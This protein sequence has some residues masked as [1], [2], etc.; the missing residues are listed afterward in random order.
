M[1]KKS[2][3]DHITSLPVLMVI[4]FIAMVSSYF[5]FIKPS[6]SYIMNSDV[7]IKNSF[8]ETTGSKNIKFLL[9]P[10]LFPEIKK[11]SHYQKDITPL[12]LQK[13]ALRM[14]LKLIKGVKDNPKSKQ[15]IFD[16][17]M[18]Y[19]VSSGVKTNLYQLKD[20]RLQRLLAGYYNLTIFNEMVPDYKATKI[21]AIKINQLIIKKINNNPVLYN[22]ISQPLTKNYEITPT[23]DEIKRQELF[24][25]LQNDENKEEYLKNLCEY[26]N[27]NIKSN[28]KVRKF[29][30][31]QSAK[32]C[33]KQLAGY[34]EDKKEAQ[35]IVKKLNNQIDNFKFLP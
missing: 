10:N 1:Q 8:L 13:A 29:A 27:Y 24:D 17:A 19:I 11:S 4:L 3:I 28:E 34:S 15:A 25:A 32:S 33:Y 14:E 5:I 6:Y 18:W 7:L 16:L 20:N 9:V 22:Q 35:T 23:E 26:Y 31:M 21:L 12:E 2:F 30:F